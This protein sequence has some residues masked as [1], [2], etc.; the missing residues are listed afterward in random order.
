MFQTVAQKK[1]DFSPNLEKAEQIGVDTE[2]TRLLHE[3]HCCAPP[4]TPMQFPPKSGCYLLTSTIW[5]RE[6]GG[7]RTRQDIMSVQTG[8]IELIVYA[9]ATYPLL[10]S[11]KVEK[12]SMVFHAL[13][14]NSTGEK[15]TTPPALVACGRQV[16]MSA[17]CTSTGMGAHNVRQ[18]PAEPRRSASTP[19]VCHATCCF[20]NTG[21]NCKIISSSVTIPRGQP[22][23]R[24]TLH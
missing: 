14:N 24:V 8:Q 20:A 18:I 1:W 16:R 11:S 2:T 13:V 9:D 22:R 12:E 15:V 3:G 4:S 5:K 19:P 7:Y 10:R 23:E 17:P 6:V 21:K